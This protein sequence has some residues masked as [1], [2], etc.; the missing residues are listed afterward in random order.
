MDR[1]LFYKLLLDDSDKD[2][3]IEEVVMETSQHKRHHYIRHNHLT[4]QERLFLDYFT[5]TPIY[6]PA[7]FRRRFRMKRS[8]FLRIQSKVEAHDSYF[9][10]KKKKIVPT[11]LVYLH[12][13]RYLLHLEC[14]HME[15]RVI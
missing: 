13:K 6:L 7:L 9:V 11:N 15:Y 3:I 2:E 5:P 8:L 12:Y 1:S 14:L 10:K 4:N